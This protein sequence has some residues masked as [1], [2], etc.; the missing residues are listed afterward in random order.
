MVKRIKALC[1]FIKLYLGLRFIFA[2]AAVRRKI[3]RIRFRW[4]MAKMRRSNRKITRARKSV[5]KFNA[6]CHDLLAKGFDP[7]GE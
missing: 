1:Y 2:R 3:R 7:E 4:V 6:V 5:D